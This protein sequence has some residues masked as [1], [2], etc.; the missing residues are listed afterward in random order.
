MH[1]QIILFVL[2]HG[3]FYI[4]KTLNLVHLKY[5]NIFI[6]FK[7]SSTNSLLVGKHKHVLMMKLSKLSVC[8][9]QSEVDM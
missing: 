5:Q 3:F 6:L 9:I 8:V 4:K 2:T 7:K 1:E